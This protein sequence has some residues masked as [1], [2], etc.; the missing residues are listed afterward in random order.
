[1]YFCFRL[2]VIMGCHT[3]L[4]CGEKN[5]E[6][7]GS[8]IDIDVHILL[9]GAATRATDDG[10]AAE[11]TITTL[12]VFIFHENGY[13][14]RMLYASNPSGLSGHPFTM[15]ATIRSGHKTFVVVGNEPAA[16]TAT[17]E[18]ATHIR[19]LKGLELISDPGLFT[20]DI[21]FAVTVEETVLPNQSAPVEIG[22]IRAVAKLEMRI[23]KDAN[24]TDIVEFL[25]ARV[26][27]TP[28]K[29]SLLDNQPLDTDLFLKDLPQETFNHTLT[30]L[31]G[32][33]ARMETYYLYERLTGPGDTDVAVTNR[34]TRLEVAL[35]FNG[36]DQQTF[37]IP[38][39]DADGQG[40]V[41]NDVRR[42]RLHRLRCIVHTKALRVN[43]TILDWEDEWYDKIL[44]EDDSNV[45]VLDWEEE[46][47]YEWD[48]PSP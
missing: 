10:T 1:M 14:D 27:D 21:P 3:L 37:I 45:V 40:Q 18:S 30:G 42:N 20:T 44:G 39:A 35:L 4:S 38:L 23:A 19:Q 2:L 7:F 11:R 12:R 29:S 6:E 43:Y 9:D 33:T 24:N 34:A 13:V 17:L 16:Y 26:V 47:P 25:H 36:T 32:D 41:V 15:R 5:P 46:L 48:L 28:T 8:E 22:L 31:P